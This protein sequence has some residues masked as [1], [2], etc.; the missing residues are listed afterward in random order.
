MHQRVTAN[1]PVRRQSFGHCYQG[2]SC[3]FLSS[4][5]TMQAIAIGDKP[6]IVPELL[7]LPENIPPEQINQLR[8]PGIFIKRCQCIILRVHLEP[9]PDWNEQ[10]WKIQLQIELNAAQGAQPDDINQVAEP[11]TITNVLALPGHFSPIHLPI[12]QQLQPGDHYVKRCGCPLY[13]F[14]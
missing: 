7:I 8:R 13:V 6:V 1:T 5:I 9:E 3:C 11:S 2:K 4:E 10:T 14:E 12:L